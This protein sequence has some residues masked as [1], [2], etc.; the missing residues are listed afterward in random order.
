MAL[1]AEYAPGVA[2]SAIVA[3]IGYLAAPYVA[4][5]VPIPNMVIALVVGIALNPIAARPAMQPG[6]AFCVRTSCAGRWRCSACASGL[7]DIAALGPG[8][9]VLIVVA[10]LAT[11]GVRFHFRAL[12]RARAGLRRAGRRRHGGLRR[13]G[14]AG[15]V[16]RGAGLSR[17]IGGHRLRRGGGQCAG[18]ARHA[19]L[20]AALHHARLRCANHRRDARRH[21]SRRR[22]SGRRRLRGVGS[23]RQHRGDRQAVPRVPFAAGGAG[24][25]LA[26]HP[27][28]G[29]STAR[30]ACR[31]RCSAS[32]SWC[33]AP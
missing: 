20:S 33:C 29:K 16:Y 11:L 13:F 3:A 28:R 9:A 19:G 12:V 22:P 30:R 10:M 14:D 24:R 15:G 18:D 6:M 21:H 23:G 1:A 26:F 17:Q 4:H 31:C 25:G 8:T 2:L 32:C 5:V 7:A 27:A